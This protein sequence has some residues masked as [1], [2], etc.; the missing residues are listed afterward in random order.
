MENKETVVVLEKFFESFEKHMIVI[1]K[2]I[3]DFLASVGKVAPAAKK[4]TKTASATS[5]SKKEVS[6][7]E[8]C[9]YKNI[10]TESAGKECTTKRMV[11]EHPVTKEELVV[12]YCKAHLSRKCIESDVQAWCS[13]NDIDFDALKGMKNKNTGKRGGGSKSTSSTSKSSAV[14]TTNTESLMSTLSKKQDI[15]QKAKTEEEDDT[16]QVEDIY[17]KDGNSMDDYKR[18][19]FDN[20]N[21]IVLE[22]TD[23]PVAIGYLKGESTFEDIQAL[24]EKHIDWCNANG[25]EHVENNE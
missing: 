10:K 17:D 18:H 5:T 9:S 1:E 12:P 7:G 6:D 24:E 16:L 14:H 8:C 21:Y 13:K 25:I 2:K 22:D 3:D 11:I 4:T 19:K 23:N 15:V 20:E